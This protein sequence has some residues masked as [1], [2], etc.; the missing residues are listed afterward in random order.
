MLNAALPA[1][2]RVIQT[3]KLTHYVLN[4]SQKY[5]AQSCKSTNLAEYTVSQ[6]LL[7]QP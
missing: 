4:L 5:S 3:H 6:S 7:Y 2:N 1:P